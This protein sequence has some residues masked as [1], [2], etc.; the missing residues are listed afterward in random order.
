MVNS[1]MLTI[2]SWTE[3]RNA[4]M[5]AIIQITVAMGIMGVTTVVLPIS[6]W[7]SGNRNEQMVRTIAMAMKM[8]QALFPA[9]VFRPFTSSSPF[10][11]QYSSSA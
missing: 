3:W 9:L 7:V 1:R 8:P 11:R 4:A 10:L 2:S 6:I 5:P